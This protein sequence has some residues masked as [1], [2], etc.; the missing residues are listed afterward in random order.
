MGGDEV[1][2]LRRQGDQGAGGWHSL[3]ARAARPLSANGT[4]YA[5]ASHGR[6]PRQS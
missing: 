5:L 2:E 6:A 3:G 1:L 4:A